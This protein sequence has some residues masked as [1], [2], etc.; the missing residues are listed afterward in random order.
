VA[1]PGRRC[2]D[3]GL[4]GWFL[5]EP[6]DWVVRRQQNQ[7]ARGPGSYRKA[8]SY[9]GRGAK[10]DGIVRQ[11][12]LLWQEGWWHHLGGGVRTAGWRGGSCVNLGIGLWGGSG[13]KS[14][15]GPGS[16][17]EASACLGRGVVGARPSGRSVRGVGRSRG[18]GTKGSSFFGRCRGLVNRWSGSR[19]KG[20]F[21]RPAPHATAGTLP[22][23]LQGDDSCTIHGIGCAAA[24]EPNRPGGRAPTEKHPPAW[25]EAPNTMEL[26]GRGLFCGRRDGGT[27]WAAV[28]ERRV[29]GVVPA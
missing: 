19:R 15:G 24:V 20:L 22:G 25:A 18:C 1:P 21:P 23:G 17:R 13:T 8:P 4:E 5:R 16:Y 27:T 9:L 26:L 3:G 6:R 2:Q 28:S 29:G 7:I 12:S 11:G 14:P 10:H